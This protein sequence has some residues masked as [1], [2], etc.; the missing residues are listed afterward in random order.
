MMIACT[1][2]AKSPKLTD[3]EKLVE[4]FEDWKIEVA[5]HDKSISAARRRFFFDDGGDIIK[6]IDYDEP[7]RWRHDGKKTK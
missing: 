4:I 3:I 5:L 2:V 6:I 7:H 1:Q